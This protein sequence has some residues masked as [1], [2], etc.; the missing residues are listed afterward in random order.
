M[1]IQCSKCLTRYRFDESLIEGNGVWVRCSRCR[2]VFFQ[3]NPAKAELKIA[4]VVA[5]D[6]NALLP[7]P[8]FPDFDKDLDVSPSREEIDAFLA[9]VEE[10]KKAIAQHHEPGTFVNIEKEVSTDLSPEDEEVGGIMKPIS[11]RD[12]KSEAEE[13]EVDIPARKPEKRTFW[14]PW[15]I[16]V[17]ILFINLLFAGIYLWFFSGISEQVVQNF[18]SIPYVSDLIGVEKKPEGFHLNQIKLQGL[19]QRFVDNL[20]AGR[21]RVIEGVA[22]NSSSLPI[23]RMQV[24][25]ELYDN[26]GAI[27]SERLSYSGNL[28]SEDE[29]ATLSEEALQKELDLPMGSDAQNIR[30]ESKGQIPFMLIF[31]N[32]PSGVVK[33]KVAPAGGERLLK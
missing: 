26:S 8:D 16:L 19:R 15:R 2:E 18:A 12:K 28:L 1:I 11:A 14:S 27:I 13:S 10:T 21:L 20:M 24:K 7:E 30:I 25:G 3:E 29:L 4:S 33:A 6:M 31:V 32:E 17:L 9:K 22:I 5:A 23:T